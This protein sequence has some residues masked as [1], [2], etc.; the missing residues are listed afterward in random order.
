MLQ[1]TAFRSQLSSVFGFVRE[2]YCGS[3]RDLAAKLIMLLIQTRSGDR[4][5]GLGH[6]K[7]AISCAW[8]G[9]ERVEDIGYVRR[10]RLV[11][12]LLPRTYGVYVCSNLGK[13]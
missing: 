3:D 11:P 10:M 5:V 12:R 7:V 2:I 4:F 6:E 1:V 8:G 9:C 13:E